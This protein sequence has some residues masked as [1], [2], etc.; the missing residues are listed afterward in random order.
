M[1]ILNEHAVEG[2]LDKDVVAYVE[3]DLQACWV[4]ALVTT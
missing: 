1:A 3:S 4:A 2:K